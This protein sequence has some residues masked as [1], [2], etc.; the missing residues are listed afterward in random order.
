MRRK[1]KAPPSDGRGD[2]KH[3][4]AGG[5]NTSDSSKTADDDQLSPGTAVIDVGPT[6]FIIRL[7]VSRAPFAVL[8][9]RRSGDLLVFDDGVN[10]LEISLYAN[11]ELAARAADAWLTR[12]EVAAA[13]ARG[14]L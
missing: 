12:S 7:F 5:W 9:C 1:W 14:R 10:R 2:P 3:V 6:N 13:Q 8:L 4:Q 11:G